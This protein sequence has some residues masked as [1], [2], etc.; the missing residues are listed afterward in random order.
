[1]EK[2]IKGPEKA[3]I[4]MAYI[5]EEAA[6]E[7]IKYFDPG[8]IQAVGRKMG[9]VVDASKEVFELVAEE[10]EKEALLENVPVDVDDYIKSVIL[11]ALGPEK[12]AEI[13]KR[14]GRRSDQG[15]IESLKQMNSRV[16]ADFIK[17]EH[18]Q[19][20]AVIMSNLGPD[21]SAQ[22][23]TFF[24]PRTRVDVVTRIATMETL[25]PGALDELEE[26]I[27]QNLAGTIGTQTTALGGV[28]AAAEILNQIDRQTETEILSTIEG[29]NAELA[30]EIQENMFT[31][32]DIGK[33]DDRGIQRI[34][35]DITNDQLILAL[36]TAEEDL[37]D[38][39]LSN[40]SERAREMLTDDMETR[41]PVKLSEVNNAQLEIVRIVRRLMSEGE[42]MAVGDGADDALV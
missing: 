10:F 29:K 9:E 21:Q 25:A 4:F 24:D 18:P 26:A 17:N 11:K 31:F 37:S 38:K 16:V 39:F 14:I 15:G 27:S 42:V 41:G 40:M 13:L 7:V 8:D 5:G 12:A 20:I 30:N 22:I 2:E 34:L 32:V 19:T 36:K 3:A 1:M 28:K 33:V 23:L 35:K 6:A